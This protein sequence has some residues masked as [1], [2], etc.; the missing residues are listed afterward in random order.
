MHNR[1]SPPESDLSFKSNGF[2]I[3]SNAFINFDF[4]LIS[5]CWK[6]NSLTSILYAL[7]YRHHY[8]S[9][10]I[11]WKFPPIHKLFPCSYI[12]CRTELPSTCKFDHF[13]HTLAIQIRLCV[14]LLLW[15]LK[16]YYSLRH[17]KSAIVF[18]VFERVE[19]K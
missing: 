5:K 3:H 14:V 12:Y 11:L 10:A 15:R 16:C 18:L 17:V 9:S 7:L 6:T 8:H 2:T 1:V 13:S 19:M 4:S